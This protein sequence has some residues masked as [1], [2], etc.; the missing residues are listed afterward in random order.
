MRAD[1]SLVGVREGDNEGMQTDLLA[2]GVEEG[3]EVRGVGLRQAGE[4]V[5]AEGASEEGGFLGDEGEGGA[6]GS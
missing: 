6:V 1:E 3:C 2:D 4:E 5:G